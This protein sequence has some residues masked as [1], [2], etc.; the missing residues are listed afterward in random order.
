MSKNDTGG[1]I[2]Q[3]KP[4]TAVI[5]GAGHRAFVYSE[6]AKTNPELLKIVGVA[7][8]NPVRRKKA[9]EYFG[10]S[11][12][13][14]FDSAQALAEKG[15]L[16]DAVINGTMDE[17]HLETAIPLLNA[18]YDMLL[19][20]PFAV[21][22][23][24]MRQIV[25]CAK[26]NNSKVMICHVLR[27]T[28]FYYAIKERIV[29]GEI[30]D[31]INIQ[32]TEHVSYHH[33]ST[34]YIRGKWAN[35]DKC[36]T[37]MLLAKCCHDIDLMMW[38][39]SETKPVSISS[40]GSKFQFKP[41]NAPANAGT[42]CMKDCPLVD[43]CVYSTKRLYIDHPD[44]WS[45]YVWDALEGIENPTIDDKIALMKTDNPYARCIYKCDNN[46]VDHQS[47]LVNFASGATGT[48]NM[49]G[50]SAEPRRNIHIIGTKGEIFGNFEE[51]KF[52][53]LK[54]NPSPD[55]HNEECDVEEV[56]LRVTGDM[57][58]AYGGHGGGDERLAEDFV[59][60]IRG[61]QPS[62]A[63][64]SIF[65]SVAGHLCVYLADKSRENGGMPVEVKLQ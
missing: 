50:G 42:I 13:M 22:E 29:N 21:C 11:E 60:F 39:M 30:G 6:L 9:M 62:L 20:K 7:D 2:M 53:V 52:T 19:E 51:S 15:R 47:V 57:V 12:D 44:R 41:E 49:V 55:A 46:V 23:E 37:T 33:L 10:F 35:S 40:F 43:E 45:F 61:E 36:H 8:P 5:V 26:K 31:I 34:S 54:I 17:Q 48:H 32:M 3:S 25:D 4:V 63:C 64:T 16:A 28:P 27:Y 58:G 38:F 59:K 14:C 18:G 56:D 65:D 24:D 1:I